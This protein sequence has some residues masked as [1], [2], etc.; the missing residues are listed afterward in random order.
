MRCEVC[1][2]KI[3]GPPNRAVIEGAKMLVCG[4][5]AKLGSVYFEAKNEPLMKKV[6]RRLPKPVI[7][8]RRQPALSET[9]TMELVEGFSSKIR[10]ARE[11]MGLT[12]EEFGKKINEKASV[13]R[14]I[15]TGKMTPDNILSEKLEHALHMKLLVPVSEPKVPTK[16]IAGPRTPPTLGDLIK[17]NKEKPAK[18]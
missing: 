6:T 2:R 10:Q 11:K 14:K 15:E 13:L 7:P 12:L 1:G 8:Q 18:K 4:E 9:E 5:C 17:V 16:A 3:I